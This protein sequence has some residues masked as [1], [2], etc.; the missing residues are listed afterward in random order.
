MTKHLRLIE[1]D[2]TE[3]L[4]AYEREEPSLEMLQGLVGGYVEPIVVLYEGK[5][6]QAFMDEDGLMKKLPPNPKATLL[7]YGRA[8]ARAPIVGNFVIGED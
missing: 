4:H 6:K 7:V 8:T 3:S 5:R 2:G 1:P